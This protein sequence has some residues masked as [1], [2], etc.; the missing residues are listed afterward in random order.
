MS[1]M[2]KVLPSDKKYDKYRKNYKQLVDMIE[3]LEK[4]VEPSDLYDDDCTTDLIYMLILK[5]YHATISQK[6]IK[7]EIIGETTL[8]QLSDFVTAFY[9]PV[10]EISWFEILI[11]N[12]VVYK[13]TGQ[14]ESIPLEQILEE[15]KNIPTIIPD[16]INK[17][18]RVSTQTDEVI[19]DNVLYKRVIPIHP[20]IILRFCN[21]I[22]KT[23][24]DCKIYIEHNMA[25]DIGVFSKITFPINYYADGNII[26][27]DVDSYSWKFIKLKSELEFNDVESSTL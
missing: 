12:T 18:G 2:L 20:Y 5:S 27:V 8:C 26:S 6:L 19:I 3:N 21:W 25:E 22:I 15:S 1:K 13:F 24:G 4:T 10:E 9:I 23:S 7:H 11:Q 14:Y 16:V 17:L